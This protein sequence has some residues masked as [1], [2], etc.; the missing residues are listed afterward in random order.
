VAFLKLDLGVLDSSLW[1]EDAEVRITFITML[2]MCDAVGLCAATAPGIARRANLPLGR[3]RT[4]LAKL[5]A[6]DLESRT[7][8]N[9]G[10]RIRRVNGGYLVLN[11]VDYQQ[12]DHGAAA[13][14]R[15]YRERLKAQRERDERDGVTRD[16]RDVT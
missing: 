8:D 11:Y 12:K 3:V 15:R 14:A 13:R 7:T 6:P 5:E 16:E 2:A 10:R 9:E 1:V 4:A